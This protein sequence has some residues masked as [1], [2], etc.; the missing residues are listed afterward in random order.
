MISRCV[1]CLRFISAIN[2]PEGIHL[3]CLSL[4]SG[5]PIPHWVNLVFHWLRP[6][7]DPGQRCPQNDHP[8]NLA[9]HAHSCLGYCCNITWSRSELLRV[10]LLAILPGCCREWSL[11]WSGLLPFHV[12]QTKRAALS[13][14]II[15]QR[16]Q[17]CGCFWWYIGMGKL[18]YKIPKMNYKTNCVNREL[19]T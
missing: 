12:V 17:S 9:T 16:S 7:R 11:P 6:F 1:C 8:E 15:L 3:T 2:A 4:Y 19:H 13:R 5:G 18:V 10:S 14:C